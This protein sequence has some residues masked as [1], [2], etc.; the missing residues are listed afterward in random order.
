MKVLC[1]G[2]CTILGQMG[3]DRGKNTQKTHMGCPPCQRLSCCLLPPCQGCSGPLH[4]PGYA[5]QQSGAGAC[6]T[7]N[8][9]A[10]IL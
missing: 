2:L 5:S 1:S 6:Y 9:Q 3:V 10:R 4:L 8:K 7:C